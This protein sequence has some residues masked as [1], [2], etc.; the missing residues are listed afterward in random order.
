M[1][2]EDEAK[3]VDFEIFADTWRRAGEG[4]INIF[5]ARHVQLVA[6]HVLFGSLLALGHLQRLEYE[7]NTNYQHQN[8]SSSTFHSLISKH[9]FSY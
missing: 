2:L 5:P 7:Y 1:I 6:R 3:G 9:I 8:S 4:T